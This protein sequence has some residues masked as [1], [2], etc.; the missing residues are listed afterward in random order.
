MKQKVMSGKEYLYEKPKTTENLVF[1]IWQNL[2]FFK[3]WKLPGKLPGS[4]FEAQNLAVG[5]NIRLFV[6]SPTFNMP[7]QIIFFTENLSD[8]GKDTLTTKKIGS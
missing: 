8:H 2:G 3:F 1:E 4:K 5:S 7:I 6:P